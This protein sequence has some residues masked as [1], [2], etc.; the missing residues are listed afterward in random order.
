MQF[1]IGQEVKLAESIAG[2]SS[3]TRGLSSARSYTV[4]EVHF[5]TMQVIEHWP[6]CP[7][8]FNCCC[9]SE[10]PEQL[11]LLREHDGAWFPSHLFV[12]VGSPR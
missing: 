4:A 10:P 12:S 3:L 11:L 8:P 2:D 6:N 5:E 7:T 1:Q 9:L